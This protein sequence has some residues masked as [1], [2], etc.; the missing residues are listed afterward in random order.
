MCFCFK[1]I[2]KKW[3]AKRTIIGCEEYL[4]DIDDKLKKYET[5]ELYKYENM[6]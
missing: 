5:D 2:I 4:H 6:R 1:N 3:F